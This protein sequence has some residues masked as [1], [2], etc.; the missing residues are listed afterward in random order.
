MILSAVGIALVH[1][2]AGLVSAVMAVFFG[3]GLLNKMTGT[4]N[5][6][7]E[8][9]K[10]NTAIGI[11]LVGVIISLLIMV[12]PVTMS[13]MNTI[14]RFTPAALFFL[15]LIIAFVNVFLAVF[16]SSFVLYLG[17]QI[18]DRLTFDINELIELKK[19]N[20][21]VALII[22]AMFVGVSLVLTGFITELITAID[23]FGLI[24]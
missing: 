7:A 9:K 2:F 19:G 14:Q 1:L 23:L 24:A 21:A 13:S 8:L 22:S 17:F 4:I 3:L 5:E 6:W 10:G 18:A 12:T 20:V 11:M 16:L 15:D